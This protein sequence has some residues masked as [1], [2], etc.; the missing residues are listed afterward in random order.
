VT[1]RSTG[2]AATTRTSNSMPSEMKNALTKASRRGRF[3]HRP[4]AVFG[5]GDDHAAEQGP[6]AATAPRSR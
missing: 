2:A 4:V 5:V 3:P 6:S 1:P